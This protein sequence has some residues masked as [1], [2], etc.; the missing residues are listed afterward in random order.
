MDHLRRKARQEAVV[1]V[2]DGLRA[3]GELLA[4]RRLLPGVVHHGE[5]VLHGDQLAA[6]VGLAREPVCVDEVAVGIVRSFGDQ[7]LEPGIA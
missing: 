6:R 1:L 4:A 7:L 2:E 3:L 5:G